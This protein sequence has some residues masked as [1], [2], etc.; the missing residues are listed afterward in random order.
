MENNQK[1]DSGVAA[2]S[3][4]NSPSHPPTNTLLHGLRR[5]VHDLETRSNPEL[6][7]LTDVICGQTSLLQ[8]TD[9][10]VLY[11][12]VDVT[13]LA[14][15]PFEKTAWLL[16][17]QSPPTD[18]QIGD[19]AAL[20]RDA[21]MLEE[22]PRDLF[23]HLPAG[24]KPIDLF[25]LCLQLLAS[26]DAECP[27]HQP[28][29]S[30]HSLVWRLLGR[31]PLFF[32]A[33]LNSSSAHQCPTDVGELTWAGRLLYWIRGNQQLPSAAEE[34]AI[35]SLLVNTC[36][37]E[38]RPACFVA[39]LSGSSRCGLTAGLQ[40]AAALFA[41]QLRRDPY[42]WA[43]RLLYSFS[44][45]ESADKWLQ[46]R[47]RPGMPFGF[48]STV[49][50]NRASLLRQAA[51]NLLG[52]LERIA[53]SAAATRLERRLATENLAPTIDWMAVKLMVMLD[54]PP[55][56]Q[57]LVIGMARLIGWAAHAIEQ[58]K[59]GVSLLPRLRYGENL[60]SAE[61]E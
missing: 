28:A 19:W 40:S 54:I 38:M 6:A 37:T 8:F 50:D 39:R 13:S 34:S 55:E 35:N 11:C 60:R 2:G 25:P 57:S 22:S 36:L 56:R 4:A 51:Q 41:G 16:L 45:P 53:I 10:D 26:F 31:L 1:T 58:Q 43:A 9:T 23:A 46:K 17:H 48:A 30:A 29:D 3:A 42:E 21:G 14:A 7:G 52:N 49:A 47:E 27:E 61:T 33:A 18:E 12:G 15:E 20:I 24:L 44:G 59:S 32:D 5:L